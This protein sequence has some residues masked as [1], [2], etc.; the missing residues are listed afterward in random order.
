MK[1]ILLIGKGE[2]GSAI[3]KIETEAGNEIS[4][5]EKDYKNNIREDKTYDVCHVCIPYSKNFVSIVFDYIKSLS[6]DSI[7][8]HSTVELGTTRKL[9]DA[10]LFSVVH[11]F[12]RGVHPNLYEGIKTFEKPIGGIDSESTDKVINIMNQLVYHIRYY[13]LLKALKWVMLLDTTYYGYNILFAKYVNEIC[14]E[15]GLDYYEVYTWAN[16]T[17]NEGYTKLGKT[18]VVRPVLYP[19][20]SEIGGHCVGPN[21]KLLPPGKLKDWC[22][23]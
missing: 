18:N 14:E 5:I 21:F 19:P 20:T 9:S 1:R 17:Y 7:I 4:I 3:E 23:K 10:T 15:Y 2:I 22:N 12:C 16:Q 13:L 11:S 8:I 6:I